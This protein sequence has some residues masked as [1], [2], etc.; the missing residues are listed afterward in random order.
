MKKSV[1]ILVVGIAIEALLAGIASWLLTQ[2]AKG[3]LVPTTSAA[4]ARATIFAVFGGAM[5]AMGGVMIAA[6]LVAKRR[7]S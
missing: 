5:G 4:D 7:K 1:R 6:W 2:M 3:N